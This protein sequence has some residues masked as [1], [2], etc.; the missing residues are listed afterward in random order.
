MASMVPLTMDAGVAKSSSPA[1]KEITRFP[2]AL[3]CA[4]LATRARVSEGGT[5]LILL[6]SKPM[7]R[8]LSKVC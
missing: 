2:S 5:L 7:K 3:S 8:P 6:E 1:A 4:A